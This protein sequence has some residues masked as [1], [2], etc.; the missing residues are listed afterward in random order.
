MRPS[1]VGK[2]DWLLP[3]LHVPELQYASG[4]TAEHCLLFEQ[5]ASPGLISAASAQ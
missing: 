1:G 4:H 5:P 2:G 3:H